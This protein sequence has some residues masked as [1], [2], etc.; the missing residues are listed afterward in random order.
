MFK[1]FFQ[2]ALAHRTRSISTAS[3]NH[4]FSSS[5]KFSRSALTSLKSTF[6]SS[7]RL[8]SNS[9]DEEDKLVV[10]KLDVDD[11]AIKQVKFSVRLGAL[12]TVAASGFVMAAFSFENTFAR[13][14]SIIIGLL[15]LFRNVSASYVMANVP[16]QVT[17]VWPRSTTTT[18]DKAEADETADEEATG[19]SL[20]ESNHPEFIDVQRFSFMN[21][22]GSNAYP[23]AKRIRVADLISVSRSGSAFPYL[24]QEQIDIFRSQMAPRLQNSINFM[25]NASKSTAGLLLLSPSAVTHVEAFNQLINAGNKN[26]HQLVKQFATS[27]KDRM[28]K[29]QS[30]LL[31]KRLNVDLDTPQK[32]VE[33]NFDYIKA[34]READEKKTVSHSSGKLSEA[35][36]VEEKQHKSEEKTDEQEK[37]DKQ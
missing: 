11:E 34:K 10:Y 19:E 21:A 9:T 6:N 28:T 18:D 2:K 14:A 30:E 29:E 22:F 15:I 8:F 25:D 17:S 20:Y 23:P 32:P 4:Q 24:T 3:R 26:Q 31:S 27:M 1:N 35:E 36:V 7:R 12:T 5:L 16:I 33:E 13:W 37:K